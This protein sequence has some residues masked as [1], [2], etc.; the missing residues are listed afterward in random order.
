MSWT[1][2]VGNTDLI[3]VS[4]SRDHGRIWSKPI[5]INPL[6][7]NGAVQGS[8]VA[9]GPNGE[10][11]VVYEVFYV[12]GLRQHFLAR[13]TNGG[14]MFSALRAITPV[15]GEVSFVVHVRHEQLRL[16]AGRPA[17][18]QGVRRL[19][20]PAESQRGRRGGAHRVER[21][22]PDLLVAGRRQRHVPGPPVHARRRG[23]RGRHR[24]R[25]LVRHPQQSRR[26]LPLR[27]LRHLLEVPGSL[28]AER[29]PQRLVDRRGNGELHRELRPVAPCLTPGISYGHSTVPLFRRSP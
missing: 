13:S 3:V 25:E 19:R 2:F 5:R 11:Y 9:V 8:Q 10:V 15:L 23:G 29:T 21:Q 27:H 22:E 7:Q 28:R 6:A 14:G 18:R 17:H 12:G 16:D 24:P 26:Y 1:R 4:R 20:R